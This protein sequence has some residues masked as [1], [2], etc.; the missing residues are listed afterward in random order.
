MTEEKWRRCHLGQQVGG[1]SRYVSQNQRGFLVQVR[2]LHKQRVERKERESKSWWIICVWLSESGSLAES[3][4]VTQSSAAGKKK[5]KNLWSVSEFKKI[6]KCILNE[7]ETI[8][9]K[10]QTVSNIFSVLTYKTTM[11]LYVVGDSGNMPSCQPLPISTSR[12]ARSEIKQH[13]NTSAAAM[14][15]SSDS[16]RLEQDSI[17]PTFTDHFNKDICSNAH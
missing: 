2:V 15:V 17:C 14:E 12:V 10:Q 16:S 4:V 5:K 11:I 9:Y 7:K 8:W 6:K 13:A 1:F 3:C